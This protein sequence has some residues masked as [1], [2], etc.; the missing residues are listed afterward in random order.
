MP[1]RH[2]QPSGEAEA[3]PNK[4]LKRKDTRQCVTKA[5]V[6]ALASLGRHNRIPQAGALKTTHT[7]FLT[8]LDASCPRSRSI[9]ISSCLRALLLA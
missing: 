6:S 5:K 7:D 1:S 3:I 8:V 9:S 2:L 4:Q